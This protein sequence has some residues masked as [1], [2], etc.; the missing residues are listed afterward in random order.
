MT[1]PKMLKSL[2]EVKKSEF[3]FL[4]EDL[5]IIDCNDPLYYTK[6]EL[7]S[8]HKLCITLIKNI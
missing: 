8:K 7:K 3:N 6:D 1:N 2:I 5:S 4:T